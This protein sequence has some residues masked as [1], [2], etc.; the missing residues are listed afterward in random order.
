M[1]AVSW[2][3]ATP[4]RFAAAERAARLGRL[5]GR[6]TGRIGALPPPLSAWTAQPRPAAAAGGRRS[7]SGGH[8]T[9]SGGRPRERRATTVARAAIRAARTRPPGTR[10]VPVPRDYRRAGALPAG[11]RELLDLLVDRLVDYKATVVETAPRPARRRRSRGAGRRAAVTGRVIVPPGLPDGWLPGR[12]RP[13]RRRADRR[14]SWTASPPWSPACAAAMR[15]RPARSSWTAARTRAGGRSRWCRTGTCAW[16]AP[17][18]SCDTVPELLA[19]LDPTRPLTLISGP[20]ATSDIELDRVE[21]VH[22]PRTLVVLVAEGSKLL[23][24]A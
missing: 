9:A 2:V 21:G 14:T 20:S 23:T 17:S 11:S 6:Q 10:A 1:A 8:A 16:C 4:A 13:R 22:G 24:A 7:G 19:R 5:L 12:R 18:R 3:M 15:A